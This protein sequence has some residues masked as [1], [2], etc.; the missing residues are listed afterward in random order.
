MQELELRHALDQL[1]IARQVAVGVEAVE[2]DHRG[3][4]GLVRLEQLDHPIALTH[5]PRTTA[6]DHRERDRLLE[7]LELVER[8]R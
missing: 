3:I 5:G 1:V 2:L 7:A 6:K 4:D 8:H